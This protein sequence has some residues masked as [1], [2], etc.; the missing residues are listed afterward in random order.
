MSCL[1]RGLTTVELMGQIYGRKTRF[2]VGASY[3]MNS[4]LKVVVLIFQT[5]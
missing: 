5:D 1:T 2:T 3:S 4:E